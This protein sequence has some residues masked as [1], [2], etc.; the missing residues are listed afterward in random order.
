METKQRSEIKETDKWDLSSLFASPADWDKGLHE[1]EDMTTE[2]PS[3]KGKLIAGKASLLSTFAWYEKVSI[4]AER[5]GCYAMLEYNADASDGENI[6]RYALVSQAYSDLGAA[7]S[8]FAPELLS[9]DD[10]TYAS[11]LDDPDFLPY[12]VFMAKN[13]RF[14][15]HVLDEKDEK[16]LALQGECGSTAHLTFSDLTNVDME[17]G[18]IDGKPLTQSTF[19]TFMISPDRNLR[20]KAYD[21]FYQVFL[22]HQHTL[23]R[24]YEGSV[25]QDI[26]ISK[27]RNYPS[28]R[29]M[30]LYPDK[31]DGA[32]YDSL[33]SSVHDGF[34]D[35]HHFYE[36]KRKAL[37]LDKLAHWD[38]YTPL[39]GGI[40]Y[41]TSYDDAVGTV[42]KALQPLGQSYVDTIHA[43]LTGERWVDRYENKGKRSGAFSSGCF[44]SKPYI[45]LNYTGETL[46][47]LFT[48]IHEGGH[49]MHSYY[50]KKNNPF[51][52]YD[53]T[54]FEAEVAS[55]FN[56]QLLA[57]YLLDHAKDDQ[58]KAFI[59]G[60]QLDDIVATL[61]RQTMFAEFEDKA[62]KSVEGGEPLT[63]ESIR[64]MYGSLLHEYF[65]DKVEFAPYSDM[66]GLRIPHFYSA[67][68]VYKYATGISAAIALCEKVLNGGEKE[69][70]DYLS[71]LK[72]GGS[73]YPM[74]SLRKAGVDMQSGEAV[75]EAIAHFRKLLSEFET[76][77]K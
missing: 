17:F 36:V 62:H 30:A 65:G 1:L 5:L 44:T 10:K 60:K 15:E 26:F 22:A 52:Q 43:G 67:F 2:A 21:Q 42:C 23:G 4:L 63:I 45:L 32:V 53:Y 12:K 14:K 11:Y 46:N 72:S 55:T 24:L 59:I 64:T 34:D 38:V 49:S 68:Y 75:K 54:I 6:R 25:K 7:L 37:H 51:F 8:F 18:S 77:L 3:Y 48:M 40:S 41:N 73:L 16:I 76:L 33:V 56:E 27:V 35:L 28:S 47:D 74:E 31:V 39:V 29:A 9:I 70:N 20:K 69:R 57:H 19:S 71:F 58:T 66:E 61:F 50:S 13:R